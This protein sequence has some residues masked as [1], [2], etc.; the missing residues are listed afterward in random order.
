MSVDLSEGDSMKPLIALLATIVALAGATSASSAPGT[1]Q[2]PR[3]PSWQQGRFVA[4]APGI[5]YRGSLV[6][7]GPTVNAA[8]AGWRG[9]QLAPL[10]AGKLRYESAVFLGH[11]GEI[12][13]VAGPAMTLTPAA[14]I[15]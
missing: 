6:E 12:D 1:R 4:L 11:D 3:S 15:D 14:A 9:T 10:Q 7:P 13:L 8:E 2:L 5:T